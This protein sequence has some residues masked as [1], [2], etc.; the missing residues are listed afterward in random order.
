MFKGWPIF[1]WALPLSVTS[2]DDQDPAMVHENANKEEDLIPI[3]LDMEF[4]GQKL[5]DCFTWNK[6]GELTSPSLQCNLQIIM[7]IKKTS[8]Y[9]CILYNFLI[10]RW[11]R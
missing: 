4:D 6:N 2:Y 5:R 7:I 3:R 11:H 8:K 10:L 1:L 9:I